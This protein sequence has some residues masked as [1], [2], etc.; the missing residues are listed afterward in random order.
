MDIIRTDG[1]SLAATPEP[2]AHHQDLASLSLVHILE[3][4]LL[5]ILID[6]TIYVN[7]FFSCAARPWNSLPI[8]CFS[9]IYDLNGFQSRIY[10]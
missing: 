6:C 8:E 3:G 4:G 5:I 1:P 7:S 10:L 9:L 2:L